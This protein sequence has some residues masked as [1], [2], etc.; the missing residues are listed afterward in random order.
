MLDRKYG[1]RVI[2]SQCTGN[3]IITCCKNEMHVGKPS[4]EHFSEVIRPVV[5][6]EDGSYSLRCHLVICKGNCR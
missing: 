2:V 4:R 1:G 5:G 6:D 3:A